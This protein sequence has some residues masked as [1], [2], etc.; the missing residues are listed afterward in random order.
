MTQ[1]C[2]FPS[3]MEEEEEVGPEAVAASTLELV[4]Q[5]EIE[6]S[7]HEG[8]GES[9]GEDK[10]KQGQ[11]MRQDLCPLISHVPK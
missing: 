11:K 9:G 2:L 1:T 8:G 3:V 7:D 5:M 6:I 4:D 10:S